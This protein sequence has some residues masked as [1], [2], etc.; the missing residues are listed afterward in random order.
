MKHTMIKSVFALLILVLFT[1]IPAH[2]IWVSGY[3][4]GWV[5]GRLRPTDVDYSAL[6]HVMHHSV[7]PKS[8][9]TL[10]TAING[11][12]GRSAETVAAAHA[13]G[14]KILLVIG[15]A[16][17][18]TAFNAATTET[19]RPKLISNLV[20]F[21]KNNGYDGVDIDWE[22]SPSSDKP[23]FDAFARELRTALTAQIPGSLMT[24]AVYDSAEGR[25]IVQ[26]VTDQFDQINMMT[27][28][29]S[30]P[31]TNVTWHNSPLFNGGDSSLPSIDKDVDAFVSAG[32][33]KAKLGIGA[34]FG[35]AV[36]KGGV[37]APKQPLSNTQVTQDVAY[38]AILSQYFQTQ[39]AKYDSAAENAYLG[40]DSSGT[41]NDVFVSYENE[42]SLTKKIEYVK[43]KGIG[44]MI[45]WELDMGY[46]ADKPAGQRDPLL[47]AVKAAVGGGGPTISPTAIPSGPACTAVQ[48]DA[49]SD[50]KVSL[51]DYETWRRVFK[52]L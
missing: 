32:I 52:A 12:N 19:N 38:T 9:G 21:V 7:L 48:G 1:T 20:T 34:E 33:P 41:A 5:Q 30:G 24:A 22:P 40:I 3:Y 51:V 18:R 13:A 26:G 23:R 6:T 4:P 50:G 29:M 2:A 49:N 25:A 28:I 36:W 39:Y 42:Q 45:I 14:K 47:Q 16:E 27:Y 10:D 37:T 11:I 15:G 44:G 17:S 31:W 8:D 43:S 46:L 35:G